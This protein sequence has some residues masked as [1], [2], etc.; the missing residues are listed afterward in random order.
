MQ[1]KKFLLFFAAMTVIG[2]AIAQVPQ[3]LS[4][5]AIV[6]DSAFVALDSVQVGIQL[7]LVSDT[8]SGTAVYSEIHTPTTSSSGLV[9]LQIGTGMTTDIFSAINW[10]DGPYYL[11]TKIDPAGGSDFS[12]QGATKLLAVP[13]AHVSVSATKADTAGR[14]SGLNFR[15]SSEGDSLVLG[16]GDFLILPGLSEA[17]PFFPPGFV[18]CDPDNPTVIDTVI[19]TTG[20]VWMDRNLGASRVAESSTDS[21]AY[22]SLFQWG[23]FADGHQCRNSDTTSALASTSA[24][25]T[26]QAWSG[27]FIVNPTSPSDWLSTQ[28]DNLWQGVDGVNNPCPSGFRLPTEAEWEE[29]IDSWGESDKNATGA[30]NSPLKLPVSGGRSRSSGD[31]FN[32]GL[33]GGNWSSSVSGSSARSRYLFFVSGDAGLFSNFRAVGGAVRCLKEQ[34]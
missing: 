34:P 7:S 9:Q 11:M 18:H 14:A 20:N 15:V 26:D 6:R 23:R 2:T 24:P 31:P 3:K 13:Y 10:A 25:T 16:N 33:F 30:Y 29:E 8:S 19:S 5:E 12:I 32:A 4:Y 17:N 28:N 21:L 27:K 1:M 22:G